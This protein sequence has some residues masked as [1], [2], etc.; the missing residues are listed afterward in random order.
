MVKNDEKTKEKGRANKINVDQD[1]VMERT[2]EDTEMKK[3]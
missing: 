1:R 2:H 3:Q